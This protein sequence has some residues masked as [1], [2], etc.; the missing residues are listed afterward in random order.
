MGEAKQRKLA[1]MYPAK[2]TQEQDNALLQSLCVE[3]V[4]SERISNWLAGNNINLTDDER[5]E[6]DAI[7]ANT[8]PEFNVDPEK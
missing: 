1:G 5:R 4:R 6:V 7:L 8:N 2:T 3:P